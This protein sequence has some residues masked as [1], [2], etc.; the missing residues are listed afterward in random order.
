MAI[1]RER[2]REI[3]NGVPVERVLALLGVPTKRSEG[4]LRFL[5]PLCGDFHTAVG[6][7]NLARCFR[8]ARSVNPIDLVMLERSSSFPD[9]VRYIEQHRARRPNPGR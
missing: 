2:L 8:C 7:A 4:C 9:A 1:E 3:R 6:R 5:C